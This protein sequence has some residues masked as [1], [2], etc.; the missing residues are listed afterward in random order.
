MCKI[1]CGVVVVAV[2]VAVVVVVVV[3]RAGRKR[4][5][6]TCW[7]WRS[8]AERL[9]W[10]GWHEEKEE[11]PFDSTT[12]LTFHPRPPGLGMKSD[13]FWEVGPLENPDLAARNHR[14]TAP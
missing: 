10:H 13:L 3:W 8:Q 7:R 11:E 9:D 5:R 12:R 1:H 14:A 2:V 6:Q 4:Q